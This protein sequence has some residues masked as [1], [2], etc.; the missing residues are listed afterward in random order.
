[1]FSQTQCIL[2][3]FHSSRVKQMK[4]YI[5]YGLSCETGIEDLATLPVMHLG[6][7]HGKKDH[8]SIVAV[9]FARLTNEESYKTAFM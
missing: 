6:Q 5:A 3:D 8:Y 7:G 1:M 2:E 9:K 4:K